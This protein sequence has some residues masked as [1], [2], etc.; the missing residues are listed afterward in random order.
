MALLSL[1]SVDIPEL[2][3]LIASDPTFSAHLL[4]F[5]NSYELALKCRVIAVPHAVVL[6]GLER[7]REVVI[8]LATS[9]YARG[10]LRA[11]ELRRCWEH[12]VA[13]AILADKVA[14]ACQAFTDIA[15]TAGIMHDIG[16]LGLLVAYPRE[17]ESIVRDAAEQCLDPLDFERE[18]FGMHHTEAGRLLIEQWGLPSEL[19]VVAGRHHDPCEGVEFD[20]LR[21]VH[22]ACRLADALGYCFSNPLVPVAPEVILA[23]L[24]PAARECFQE[25]PEELRRHIDEQ[26]RAFDS[27]NGEEPNESEKAVKN[28]ADL[29]EV[30]PE[31]VFSEDDEPAHAH[32][33]WPAVIAGTVMGILAGFI[34]WR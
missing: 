12:S 33:L 2:S 30:Q 23:E 4:Q 15:Y 28:Q 11:A 8:T 9:R 6:L 17:Y 10:G 18:R 32:N 3:K 34:Y 26:L 31:A 24:P 7:A 5:A 1:D 20:L 29:L 14:R 13:T 25:T 21:I 19:L 27:R 16:R 22:I